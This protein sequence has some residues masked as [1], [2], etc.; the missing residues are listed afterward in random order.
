[1]SFPIQVA[2]KYKVPLMI[3]GEEGFSELVGMLSLDYEQEFT[4]WKRT[5]YSMRGLDVD[6]I[7]QDPLAAKE[8][9]TA[10][11]LAPIVYPTDDEIGS[12]G[13]RGIYMGN[14][15]PWTALEQ[16][17]VADK[18][19]GFNILSTPKERSF[20][21]YAK[22]DDH[23][24]AVHDYLRF[25]KFGYGRCTDDAS[26]EIRASRLTRREAAPLITAYD[27]RKPVESW[28]FYLK[29]LGLTEEQVLEAIEPDRDPAIWKK[30]SNGWA[31][32]DDITNHLDDPGVKEAELPQSIDRT[33][34]P[35]NAKY[36]WQG[37][38]NAV[39]ML[40]PGFVIP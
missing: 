16:V 30:T 6:E 10:I 29:A 17:R 36:Y 39:R 19:W 34:S 9:I 26:T 8:G 25:L 22:T 7:L 13:F 40:E 20:C 23:S 21:L 38:P 28:N 1:M 33:F 27:Q 4:K 18:E 24:N 5:E 12:L 32:L 11:D 2:V 31:L 3:W 15:M 14:Y 37:S 35:E